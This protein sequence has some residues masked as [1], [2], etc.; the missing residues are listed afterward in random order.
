M[1]GRAERV[2]E[3][4]AAQPEAWL[5]RVSQAAKLTTGQRGTL[6]TGTLQAGP[7]MVAQAAQGR[8]VGETQP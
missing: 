3:S 7:Q 1:A 4:A 6:Q 5:V 2:G 8:L